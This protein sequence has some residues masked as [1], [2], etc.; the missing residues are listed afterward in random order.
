MAD[1]HTAC[2]QDELQHLFELDTQCSAVLLATVYYWSI[3]Y[4]Y[5]R[6]LHLNMTTAAVDIAKN[7]AS[8]SKANQQG[9]TTAFNA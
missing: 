4:A 2:S 8:E 9:T 5:M 6:L 7:A 3:V 1:H